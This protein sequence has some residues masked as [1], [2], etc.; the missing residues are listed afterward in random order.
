MLFLFLVCVTAWSFGA[1]SDLGTRADLPS[2]CRMMELA[3]PSLAVDTR[4]VSHLMR[5]M[6]GMKEYQLREMR[7]LLLQACG[8]ACLVWY[9]ND[10]TPMTTRQT[11]RNSVGQLQFV[12][13][14]RTSG[15]FVVQRMFVEDAAGRRCVIISEPQRVA[16]KTAVT[17]FEVF[18]Q[19]C[20][21]S[22]SVMTSGI[23]I[24]AYCWDGALFSACDRLHR[25][26]MAC[27]HHQLRSQ[28]SEGECQLNELTHWFVS[29]KCVLHLA[30]GGLKRGIA[31]ITED[32]MILKSAWVTLE[33]LRSSLG[34]LLCCAPAWINL[35][36]QFEDWAMGSQEAL[37]RTLGIETEVADVLVDL[38]LRWDPSA[39]KLKVA[40]RHMYSPTLSSDILAVMRTTWRFRSFSDSRWIGLGSCAR[41][42]A[43]A[44]L[45]GL[46]DLVTFVRATPGQSHYFIAGFARYDV[47]VKKMMS[48][49]CGCAYLPEAVLSILVND[50]RLATAYTQIEAEIGDEV[51]WLQE[52]PQEVWSAI[53]CGMGFRGNLRDETI[54]ASVTAAAYI[55][56]GLRYYNKFPWSL[57]HGDPDT[58]LSALEAL[59]DCPEEETA[60]KIWILL[61]M[62]FCRLALCS[63]LDRL[64]QVC[65]SAM[66]T[67]Q[68]HCA[69]STM[70]K[71]HRTYGDA[72]MKARAFALQAKPMLSEDPREARLRRLTEQLAAIQHRNP[73]KL[74]GTQAY[75]SDLMLLAARWKRE[76]R[77]VG[78]FFTKSLIRTHHGSWDK[79]NSVHKDRYRHLAVDMRE[80]VRATNKELM[81]DV[82]QQIDL[83]RRL[84]RDQVSESGVLRVST[85]RLSLVALRQLEACIAN[86]PATS[87]AVIE[88]C[89]A[90][91]DAIGS[92]P[93]DVLGTLQCFDVQ[94]LATQAFRYPWVGCVSHNR[95]FFANCCFRWT[96]GDEVLVFKFVYALQNPMLCAFVKVRLVDV[97]AAAGGALEQL[98]DLSR[99][100]FDHNFSVDWTSFFFSDQKF[101]DPAA[102]LEVL[103][104]CVVRP[105]RLLV[106]DG[107]WIAYDI[108]A[109]SLRQGAPTAEQQDEKLPGEALADAPLWATYPWLQGDWHKFGHEPDSKPRVRNAGGSVGSGDE[110]E[111]NEDGDLV[112]MN[113]ADVFDELHRLRA[114]WK[115]SDDRLHGDFK[116]A[117]RGG[118]WT[119]AHRGVVA[120]SV[121]GEASNVDSIAFSKAYFLPQSGT[122]SISKFTE[123]HAR[124]LAAAWCD[125]M[126]FWFRLWL[127]RG[128]TGVVEFLPEDLTLYEEP[129]W[130]LELHTLGGDVV[131]MRLLD[132]R[133]IVPAKSSREL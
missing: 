24:E 75:A 78:K 62:G 19:V 83:V 112:G 131:Q 109:A 111:D 65:H 68:A 7:T 113:A 53:S 51:C 123:Q 106:S 40:R 87:A 60:R 118:V 129:L 1:M 103:V 52:T 124:T 57:L 82:V 117:V 88:S 127:G 25:Q 27:W 85:C 39:R 67:E 26:Y 70:L 43:S 38:Q 72:T 119:A 100:V 41:T 64:R 15:E 2:V 86:F 80:E 133:G 42:L 107:D 4:D 22:R 99:Y 84:I 122:F 3:Q 32:K 58:A 37:W 59:E 11:I 30:H 71:L 6:L 33:S 61:K 31:N 73:N 102:S 92:P 55:Q 105:S 10:T 63:G 29:V 46:E 104:D 9:S 76:G 90:A 96:L 35:R 114:A 48:I 95:D 89:K 18:R 126:Q 125:R 79:M 17:H 74:G 50:D 108:V 21:Y 98:H 121:R 91:C 34:Q 16:N 49:L 81:D 94:R 8:S 77:P 14:V 28:D 116:V 23:L 47:H 36:L 130:V 115:E 120:D 101:V 56:E 110:A 132:I 13:R 44:T 20:P 69:G 12:Q 97:V 45:L 128:G 5:C 66:S 54:S 93:L